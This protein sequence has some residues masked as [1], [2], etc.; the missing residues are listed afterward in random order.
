MNW[1]TSCGGNSKSRW[2]L[3]L[4]GA[5]ETKPHDDCFDR[6][7]CLY[8]GN[9][10]STASSLI[11]VK[12]IS[13]CQRQPGSRIARL[14]ERG[15]VLEEYIHVTLFFSHASAYIFPSLSSNQRCV[16]SSVNPR[17]DL[18]LLSNYA[19]C[20]VPGQSHIVHIASLSSV[21]GS[22]DKAENRTRGILLSAC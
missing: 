5:C 19:Q 8:L 17:N 14:G 2:Q 22:L 13:V 20:F 6:L 15:G 12:S 1:R 4:R 18:Y 3:W 7:F 21:A 9:I 16:E 11:S 10:R